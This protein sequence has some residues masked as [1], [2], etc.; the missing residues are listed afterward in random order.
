MNEQ[1]VVS[2]IQSQINLVNIAEKV[3]EQELNRIGNV[4]YE[5]YMIDEESRDQW[6]EKYK[7]YLDLAAQVSEDKNFPWPDASNV[8]YPLIAI[9]SMQFAARS[10]EAIVP[11]NKLV[12]AKVVG[13]DPDGA[14]MDAA[15]RVSRFMSYQLIEEMEDWED[16]MD[17]LC[18]ILPIAGNC[19]KKTYYDGEQSLSDMVLPQDLCVNYFAKNLEKASRKTHIQVY[20]ENEIYEMMAS[21]MWLDVDLK[22][23]NNQ[24]NFEEKDTDELHG[25]TPPAFDETAP[26]TF[27]EQHTFYDLDGDGYAEPYIITIH[28]ES[29]Q[30]VRISARYDAANVVQAEDG[31]I[32]KITPNEYFTNYIF[33]PDPVSGVYGIGFG[34]LLGPINEAVNTL[35]NQLIDAG[36]VS[37][38]PS[39]FMSKQVRLDKGDVPLRPGEFRPTQTLADDLRK[40]ILP[41][42]VNQPS[43]VLFQ[44]LGLMIESGNQ[45]SSVTDIM[46]GVSPGQNQ[47]FSTTNEVLKQ[48]LKVFNAIHKRI[49]R[50]FKK[51]LKKLYK[52]NSLYLPPEKY[53]TVLDAEIPEEEIAI[54]AKSDFNTQD[55]NV[56]PEASPQNSSMLE[57]MEKA[58]QLLTLIQMGTINPQE[59]TTRILRAGGHHGI[60]KLMEMPEPGPNFDQEIKMK[61]LEIRSQ[62]VQVDQFKAQYQ[63]A[64]D[65]ANAALAYAKAQSEAVNAQLG[66]YKA[67]FDKDIADAKMML[68]KYKADLKA[69]VDME[70]EKEKTKQARTKTVASKSND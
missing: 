34:V 59:A 24:E 1:D 20:T 54:I 49:H 52:L 60:K 68:D 4:V 23:Y 65:E 56:V 25:I 13:E 15:V 42:P 66:E 2:E 43:T 11:G 31:R 21:G 58:N 27:L 46:K 3:D 32:I 17:R 39:G 37:N 9:A 30:V 7:D 22:N 44:L 33:V 61:E 28:K 67:L 51:E 5:G 14:K 55:L 69:M 6:K 45:L 18:L 48:G 26:L 36:T 10:Y 63:A 19:F 38:L 64:R 62:E 12:H 53:F 29:Q 47:P 50:G 16:E 35:I 70:I 8:K 41:L 40:G 57:E